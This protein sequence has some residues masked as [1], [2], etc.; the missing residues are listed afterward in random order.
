MPDDKRVA[1]L[2]AGMHKWGKWGRPFVEYGLAA[3]RRAGRRRAPWPRHRSSSPAPTPSATAT[4]A[5]S[6]ARR[7]AQALGGPAHGCASVYAACATGAYAINVARAQILA[8]MCDVALV[9]GAD[10]TPKGFFAPSAATAG[11][12]DWLRFHLHR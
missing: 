5:S 8:G 11:R 6:P 9:V 2:G 3:R 10:T 7:I 4:P 1:V 12:P